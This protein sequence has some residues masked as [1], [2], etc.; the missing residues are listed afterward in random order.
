[1]N[2]IGLI[3][4]QGTIYNL[5]AKPRIAKSPTQEIYYNGNQVSVFKDK[6]LVGWAL[7]LKGGKISAANHSWKHSGKEKEKEMD[8]LFRDKVQPVL[9]SHLARIYPKPVKC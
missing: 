4:F 8:A 9:T 5:R 3:R 6:K 2:S 7:V 1:V